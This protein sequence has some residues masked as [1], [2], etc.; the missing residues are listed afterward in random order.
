RISAKLDD[1]A[2]LIQ[3]LLQLASVAGDNSLIVKAKRLI[4]TV[5]RDFGNEDGFFYYSS[6]HQTDI[7]VRKVDVYD[8]ATPSANAAMAYNLVVCG[9]C[10]ENSGWI[11]RSQQMIQRMGDM[12]LCYSYSFGIWG[13]LIQHQ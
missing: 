2:Y 1:Y 10:T 3:A 11:D 13:R 7:P 12:A 9:M 4:E 8:G 5:I 6:V